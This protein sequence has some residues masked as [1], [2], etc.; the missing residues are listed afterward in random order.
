MIM[1]KPLF[2]T[3]SEQI[4]DNIRKAI[5]LGDLK[6]GMP[7]RE[8]EL[9]KSYNVSRGPV[10]DALKELAKEGFLDMV[11]NVGVKVAKPPS[12]ETLQLIINLRRQIESFVLENTFTL[13]ENEDFVELEKLLHSFKFA[14]ETKNIHDIIDMDMQFHG[15]LVSKTN[16]M[17]I[18]DLWQSTVNRMLFRYNRFDNLIDSYN[19]HIEI[20]NSLKAKDKEKCINLL[21][22]NIQ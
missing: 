16:D 9:S 1:I 10:R 20:F 2:L 5:I 12:D 7:L 15:F 19:E 11:P 8:A 6:E 13:F 21:L 18:K 3:I 4:G 22:S 17:H 14:C